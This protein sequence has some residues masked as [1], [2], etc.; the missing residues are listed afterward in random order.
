MAKRSTSRP[1]TSEPSAPPKPRRTRAASKA[2]DTS[3]G[4]GA[5]SREPS[6]DEIRHRAYERYLERGGN[7]GRH[8]DDWVEAEKELR[9]RK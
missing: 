1:A 9:N 3:S 6:H 5:A 7:H 2:A 4:N 8:F